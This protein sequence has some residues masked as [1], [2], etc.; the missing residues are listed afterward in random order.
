LIGVLPEIDIT[1]SPALAQELPER[2][3]FLRHGQTDWNLHGRVMG[4]RDIALNAMGSAQANRSA[5]DIVGLGLTHVYVSPLERCQ[6]TSRAICTVLNL[7]VETVDAFAERNWGDFEG[8]P[9]SARHGAFD[10]PPNG[11]TFQSFNQRVMHGFRQIGPKG[12]PLIV[13]H[14][15]VFRIMTGQDERC[16]IGHA[17]PVILGFCRKFIG[18]PSMRGLRT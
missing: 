10:A 3:V 16:K 11:E 2:L 9:S 8:G 17:E 4:Q 5:K 7:A 13:A 12:Y 6:A 14:S 1:L 15:G 18:V